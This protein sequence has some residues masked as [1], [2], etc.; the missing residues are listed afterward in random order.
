ML[1]AKSPTATIGEDSFDGCEQVTIHAAAGS[2][3][4]QYATA[5]NIPFVAI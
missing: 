3:A 1:W 4:E 2:T 5:H